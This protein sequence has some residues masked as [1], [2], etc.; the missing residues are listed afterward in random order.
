MKFYDQTKR[1]YRKTENREQATDFLLRLIKFKDAPAHA[2]VHTRTQTLYITWVYI[3]K[4]AAYLQLDFGK[5]QLTKNVK[6]FN[7]KSIRHKITFLRHFH[8]PF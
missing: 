7:R 3:F 4:T 8:I 2:H 1:D 6:A 5:S